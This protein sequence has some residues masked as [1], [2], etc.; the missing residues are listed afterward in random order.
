VS[1]LPGGAAVRVGGVSFDLSDIV[2][3]SEAG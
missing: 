2:D 3:I 1:N